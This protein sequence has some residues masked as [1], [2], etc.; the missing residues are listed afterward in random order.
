MLLL[1]SSVVPDKRRLSN[2]ASSIKAAS[3]GYFGPL[4]GEWRV[5]YAREGR[6]GLMQGEGRLTRFL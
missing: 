2:S 5:I 4:R 1:E 3:C 6:L